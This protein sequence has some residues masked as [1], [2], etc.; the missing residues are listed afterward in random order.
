MFQFSLRATTLFSR[1]SHSLL[2][3]IKARLPPV[4]ERTHVLFALSTNAGEEALETVPKLWESSVGCLTAPW[5][6]S[7]EQISCSILE[8]PFGVGRPFISRIVG[9]PPVQ[10]GRYHAMR[11]T[12]AEDEYD[13]SMMSYNRAMGQTGDAARAEEY[14]I[15]E[16]LNP[17]MCVLSVILSYFETLLSF[18][19]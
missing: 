7:S 1:N 6:S 9:R 4:P 18:Y 8:V 2:D 13:S 3:A 19:H 17:I 15:P 10:V 11:K 14:P 5:P 16:G 12:A